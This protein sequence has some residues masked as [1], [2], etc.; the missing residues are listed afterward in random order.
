MVLGTGVADAMTSATNHFRGV[1]WSPAMNQ[2]SDSGLSRGSFEA[3]LPI[4]ARIEAAEWLLGLLMSSPYS[5]AILSQWV[6][7]AA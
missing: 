4:S 6:L 7:I 1:F 2:E 3:A 5:V